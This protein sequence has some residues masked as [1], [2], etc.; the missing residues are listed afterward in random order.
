MRV[1][2]ALLVAAAVAVAGATAAAGPANRITALRV[3]GTNKIPFSGAQCTADQRKRRLVAG[4]LDCSVRLV[5]RTPATFS[6]SFLY[7]GR[8][9]YSYSQRERHGTHKRVIGVYMHN[10]AMPG[11][12]YSCRFALGRLKSSVTF[13][14]AGPVGRILGPAA[15]LAADSVGRDEC[16][17]DEAGSSFPPTKAVTCSAVFPNAVGK[18]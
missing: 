9:Q 16:P 17:R 11:G 18:S 12:T 6:A 15:C 7:G 3:C 8:L 1:A 2:V 10:T 5:V 13:K 14:S 4:E